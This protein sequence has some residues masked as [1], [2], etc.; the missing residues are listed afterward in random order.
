MVMV[1]KVGEKDKHIN[2]YDPEKKEATK[3]TQE[4]Y[5]RE[6]T[7]DT[8]NR[9]E[10]AGVK[11]DLYYSVQKDEIYCRL[12]VPEHRLER[13]ADRTDYDL[14]LDHAKC[15]EYGTALGI[16]LAQVKD[17][18]IVCVVCV[19]CVMVGMVG[20][21]VMVLFLSFDSFSWSGKKAII[22]WF[23]FSMALDVPSLI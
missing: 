16:R 14:Q 4:D 10:K 21:F 23:S 9:M 22:G 1:F 20:L 15:L 5:F 19:V 8:L 13:E 7:A 2:V 12:G 18:A 11:T 17:L 3:V 6:L